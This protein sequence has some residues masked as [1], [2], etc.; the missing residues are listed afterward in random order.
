VLFGVFAFIVLK[1]AGVPQPL[2]LALLAAILDAVPIVGVP[3][4]T[5]PAL[6]LAATVSVPTVVIVL[7]AY[8]VYQQF[9][10]YFLVP[11]VFGNAL[12]VSSISIL[13]GILVGGQLLGIV[14]TLL[15]LPITAAIPV[16]ERVWNEEIP[17][18]LAEETSS[19]PG[20]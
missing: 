4:A 2:L 15:A 11:R 9:E 7:V 1:I 14:G 10:N 8:T 6:L 20:G 17:P 19:P 18:E 3:V 12:Q 16:F 13:L 5:I